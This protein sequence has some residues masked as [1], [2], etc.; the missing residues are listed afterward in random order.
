MILCIVA[1]GS[2]TFEFALASL[3]VNS[4]SLRPPGQACAYSIQGG[5]LE[6]LIS[7]HGGAKNKESIKTTEEDDLV[8]RFHLANT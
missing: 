1:V 7:E 3:I 5:V 8:P 6:K 4:F 2:C